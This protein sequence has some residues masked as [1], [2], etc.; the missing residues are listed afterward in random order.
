MIVCERDCNKKKV[1]RK[2]KWLVIVKSNSVE[3]LMVEERFCQKG[4]S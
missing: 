3:E 2:N 4:Q 1:V